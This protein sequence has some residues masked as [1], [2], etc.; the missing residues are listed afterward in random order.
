MM[1]DDEKAELESKVEEFFTA[2][3][4]KNWSKAA[5]AFE[6]MQALA[7][8]DSPGAE[9]DEEEKPDKKPLAILAFGKK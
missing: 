8:D 4:A 3:E 5:D 1:T 7:D 9:G 2:G 6:D